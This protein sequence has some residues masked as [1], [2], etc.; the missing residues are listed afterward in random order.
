MFIR[1]LVLLAA[2]FGLALT[3]SC[4][5]D[6]L[7]KSDIAGSL[8]LQAKFTTYRLEIGGRTI[9]LDLVGIIHVADQRLYD[10]AK[11]VLSGV[12]VEFF[13]GLAPT[14]FYG[15]PFVD[16]PDFS[17]P[18]VMV[19]QTRLRLYSLAKF[20]KDFFEKTGRH[21]VS[22]QELL[23]KPGEENRYTI[24]I[25]EA[26]DSW[27]NPFVL[28]RDDQVRGPTFV[29][30]GADGKL[31]GTGFDADLSSQLDDL[32]PKTDSDLMLAALGSS[33]DNLARVAHLSRQPKGFGCG[34]RRFRGCFFLF[35]FYKSQAILAFCMAR[36]IAITSN[37]RLLVW[38]L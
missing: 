18:E 37:G 11:K 17:A 25:A 3:T 5:A 23:G 29:S 28:T 8:E 30:L 26:L 2:V 36:V 14:G 20:A 4:S 12:D 21:P 1:M 27:G 19:R 32:V 6:F 13:E 10:E 33:Y 15:L 22:M 35:R 7:R 38:D 16:D 24:S 31:G 9:E 34:E